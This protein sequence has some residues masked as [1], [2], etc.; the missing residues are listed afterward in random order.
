[1]VLHFTFKSCNSEVLILLKVSGVQATINS[2]RL[3]WNFTAN[4]TIQSASNVYTPGVE[5]IA[6][7]PP[8]VELQGSG[9]NDTVKPFSWTEIAFL[10]TKTTS[11]APDAQYKASLY[12]CGLAIRVLWLP[13]LLRSQVG[14]APGSAESF[15]H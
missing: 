13:F 1:M 9:I 15:Q 2:W 4:E 7:D 6:L 11:P 14:P 12:T 3:G 10:G 8:N 5:T